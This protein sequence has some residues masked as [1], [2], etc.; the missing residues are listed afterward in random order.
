MYD[1][2]LAY[3]MD[4]QNWT[5]APDNGHPIFE[6]SIHKFEIGSSNASYAASLYEGEPGLYDGEY[7]QSP[8]SPTFSSA[9]SHCS[10][11]M[12][13]EM[14]D[15]PPV[16]LEFNDTLFDEQADLEELLDEELGELDPADD[17]RYYCQDVQVGDH[18]C[19]FY[20]DR[21]CMLR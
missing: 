10:G 1:M 16:K 13:P 20:A 6:D 3:S 12:S 9:I 11:A 19:D 5:T 4:T 15:T 7:V 21:K 8:T 17:G 2:P 14:S 18:A